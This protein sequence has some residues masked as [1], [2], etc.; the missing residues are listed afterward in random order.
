MILA[1]K[2]IS[3][4]EIFI[5]MSEIAESLNISEKTMF[6]KLEAGELDDKIAGSRLKMLLFLLEDY[7]EE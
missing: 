5:E 7:K 3:K 2:D 1:A 6:E 4:E